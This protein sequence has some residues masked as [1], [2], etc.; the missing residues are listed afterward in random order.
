M[1]ASALAPF[2]AGHLSKP[3]QAALDQLE[4]DFKLD[5]AL[6][7]KTLD[8]F[9]YEFKQGLSKVATAEDDNLDTFLPM[10]P[11]F[12]HDV[13]N[14]SEVGD[15]LALDLVSPFQSYFRLEFIMLE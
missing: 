7:Q 6:L 15:F 3:Q 14:G 2:P 13:P 4:S 12:I 9:L 10:I 5:K 1:S 8:R 11:T